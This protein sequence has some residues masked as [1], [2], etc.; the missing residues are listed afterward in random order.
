MVKDKKLDH[1]AAV[2]SSYR[3]LEAFKRRG[4]A[5]DLAGIMSFPSM[6][7]MCNC[8]L[9]REPPVEYQQCSV[10]QLLAADRAAWCNLIEV[11]T[12]PRPDAARVFALDT[13]LE[14]ALKS[15]EVS[16]T[17]MPAVSKTSRQNTS[18]TCCSNRKARSCNAERSQKRIAQIQ[19]IQSLSNESRMRFV[20]LTAR[21]L[22]LQ[23]N[24]FVLICFYF[25]LKKCRGWWSIHVARWFTMSVPF[26][27]ANIACWSIKR[28]DSLSKAKQ[29]FNME[30]L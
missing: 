5:L 8:V 17:L 4:L 11:N 21:W 6:S 12:Q 27:M 29:V 10:S 16:L 9:T 20:M 7:L 13:K 25:S 24:P 22:H 30:R 19:A 28:L 14:E 2:Q 23:V 3:A 26:A 15:Y 1:E 18:C